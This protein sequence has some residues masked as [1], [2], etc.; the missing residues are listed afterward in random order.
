MQT[1]TL[2]ALGKLNA[3]YYAKAAR[4]I[5]K[6]SFGLLQAE[7]RGAAGGAIAE[8]NASP[9]VIGKALEKEA[10]AILT[11]V[12]KGSS[13]AAAVR[14]RKT[15]NQRGAGRVSGRARGQRRGGRGVRDRL[16]PRACGQRKAD[17]VSAAF[18]EQND[19]PAPAWR[20]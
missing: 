4:R 9:A 3:D 10:R 14:R 2:I 13:L 15:K 18:H 5:C 16:V 11:A 8:K 20:G 19:I 1:I 17:G 12:P 6:A 7:H